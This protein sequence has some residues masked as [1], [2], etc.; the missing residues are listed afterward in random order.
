L[1]DAAVDVEAP[2]EAEVQAA[3]AA[4]GGAAA[5]ASKGAVLHRLDLSIILQPSSSCGYQVRCRA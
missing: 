1:G 5:A 4:A 2:T 3:T